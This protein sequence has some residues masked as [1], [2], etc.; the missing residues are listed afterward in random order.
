MDLE[1]HIDGMISFGKSKTRYWYREERECEERG[2]IGGVVDG[3]WTMT[4]I[5]T[6]K[7]GVEPTV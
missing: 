6:N 3:T 2:F 1:T 5:F 4:G 7:T